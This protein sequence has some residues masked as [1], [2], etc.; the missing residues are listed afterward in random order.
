MGSQRVQH[1]LASEQGDCDR[2]EQMCTTLKHLHILKI[3]VLG[4][5]NSTV[6]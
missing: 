1:N 5:Q 3:T 6:G 2:L 4:T